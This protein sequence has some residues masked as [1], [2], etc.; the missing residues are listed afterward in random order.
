MIETIHTHTHHTHTQNTSNQIYPNQKMRN[1]LPPEPYQQCADVAGEMPCQHTDDTN[2]TGA[3][4]LKRSPAIRTILLNEKCMQ[5]NSTIQQSTSYTKSNAGSEYGKDSPQSDPPLRSKFHRPPPQ[6]PP[7]PPK[8]PSPLPKN[9]SL[10][11]SSDPPAVDVFLVRR[12]LRASVRGAALWRLDRTAG[13][14]MASV[15]RAPAEM[16]RVPPP[17]KVSDPA[18]EMAERG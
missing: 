14:A 2:R 9:P 17:W 5:C 1:F 7:P 8:G 13:G 16:I 15:G 12:N 11:P 6:P 18:S 3:F 4:S 10:S